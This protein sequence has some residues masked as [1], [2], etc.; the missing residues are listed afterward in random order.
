MKEALLRMRFELACYQKDSDEY[1]N[2]FADIM[3][4]LHGTDFLRVRPWG[5]L[6][7]KKNDGYLKSSRTLFQVYA[8]KSQSSTKTKAKINEDFHEALPYWKDHFDNWIF[9][10]NDYDGL[11]PD[12]AKLLLDLN[13]ENENVSIDQWGPRRLLKKFEQ[14]ELTQKEAIVGSAPTTEDFVG[15]SY[16][17]LGPV[18]RNVARSEAPPPTEINPVPSDKVAIN[19]LPDDVVSLLKLGTDKAPLVGAYFRDHPDPMF[20]EDVASSFN[21]RYLVLKSQDLVAGAIFRELWLM[22]RGNADRGDPSQEVAVLAVLTYLFE[23]CDIYEA[24]EQGG[25]DE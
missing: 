10:H 13:S 25:S 16:D 1:Q 3:E 2:L 11:G 22:A 8:P 18:I 9:V 12:V 4:A 7:D 6:G 21:S 15:L 24:S 20:G 14:L 23:T 19:K 17:Q 5:N